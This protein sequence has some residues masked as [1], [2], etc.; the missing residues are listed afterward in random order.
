MEEKALRLKR[1]LI[2]TNAANRL[3]LRVPRP[4]RIEAIGV[5]C[6]HARLLDLLEAALA[7]ELIQL[8][9]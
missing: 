5:L 2:A 4:S 6:W 9:C 1:S 7:P 8:A 3:K